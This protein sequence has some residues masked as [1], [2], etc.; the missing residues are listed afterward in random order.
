[1][2]AKKKDVK[3]KHMGLIKKPKPKRNVKSG[4]DGNGGDGYRSSGKEGG[5]G[6]DGGLDD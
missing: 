6:Y 4:S 1:M 5:D 2:A 3:R